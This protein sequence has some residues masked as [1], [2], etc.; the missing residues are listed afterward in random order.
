M[1]E[2]YHL[3][4]SDVIEWIDKTTGKTYSVLGLH[5]ESESGLGPDEK[6]RYWY[7]NPDLIALVNA[8]R[9]HSCDQCGILI[10]P[11][12]NIFLNKVIKPAFYIGISEE[13]PPYPWGYDTK[14]CLSCAKEIFKDAI[15][16]RCKGFC[17]EIQSGWFKTIPKEEKDP[18]KLLPI[19]ENFLLVKE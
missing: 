13:E 7:S 16:F 1:K 8:R 10:N 12:R 3:F 17:G 4:P 11:E 14:L 15:V 9:L 2:K 19:I 6:D 18:I 5:K